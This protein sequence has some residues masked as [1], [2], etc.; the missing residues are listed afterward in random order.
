MYSRASP[1]ERFCSLL[2]LARRRLHGCRASRGSRRTL[3]RRRSRSS[4]SRATR[5][6]QAAAPRRTPVSEDEVEFVV[7][8]SRAAAAAGRRD[9]AAGHHRRRRQRDAARRRS[10]STRVGEAQVA[11]AARSIRGAYLGGKVPVTVT[12]IAAHRRTA[13]A[14]SSCSRP[15]VRRA[16]AEVA[17]AGA[18][19]SYYSRTPEHAEGRQPRRAVRA[20]R[21][22]PADRRRPGQAVVVQ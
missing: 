10:I 19:S 8:L 16:G 4:R 17:A 18:A 22:H 7:R 20:A 5:R 21:R 14:A 1:F 2:V 9:R 11:A 13:R 15:S 3:S 6:A 12:G